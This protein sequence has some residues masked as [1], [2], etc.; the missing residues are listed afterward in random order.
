MGGP[1][2]AHESAEL[3]SPGGNGE[4]HQAPQSPQPLKSLSFLPFLPGQEKV[5]GTRVQADQP[6]LIRCLAWSTQAG[7]CG[8]EVGR[9]SGPEEGSVQREGD[10]STSRASSGREQPPAQ[11]LAQLG[12]RRL[13]SFL[14]SP[15]RISIPVDDVS[16][17]RKES[18]QGRHAN[19]RCLQARD[20]PQATLFACADS[21]MKSLL[22]FENLALNFA[23]KHFS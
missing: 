2:K 10:S 9:C 17:R 11:A 15:G 7:C 19:P 13:P 8:V 18:A 5:L 6:D 3:G 4:S 12:Q 16:L 20:C 14:R 23:S 22:C 21:C 1:L